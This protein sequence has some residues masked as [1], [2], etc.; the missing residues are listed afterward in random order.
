[1]L[2]GKL[3]N[4]VTF[5]TVTYDFASVTNVVDMVAAL[6]VNNALG[7]PACRAAAAMQARR[8]RANERNSVLQLRCSSGVLPRSLQQQPLIK[9]CFTHSSRLRLRV[10]HHNIVPSHSHRASTRPLHCILAPILSPRCIFAFPDTNRA[11]IPTP[12]QLSNA[13]ALREC[14]RQRGCVGSSVPL[15]HLMMMMMRMMMI[16]LRSPLLAVDLVKV[17][18]LRNDVRQLRRVL[19]VISG[20]PL[21]NVLHPAHKSHATRD[22]TAA[23]RHLNTLTILLGLSCTCSKYLQVQRET[24]AVNAQ[25]N[26]YA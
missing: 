23:N 25:H 13:H 3:S 10:K 5:D 11:T 1:M 4:T 7:D 14:S 2:L 19:A 21:A 9:H 12:A 15:L 16:L 6:P 20:V 26:A 17:V 18:L 24:A 22:A 8:V